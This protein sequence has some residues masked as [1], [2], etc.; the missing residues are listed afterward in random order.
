MCDMW[1][2][3]GTIY[4]TPPE[5]IRLGIQYG[6]SYSFKLKISNP[7]SASKEPQEREIMLE[8][9]EPD[10]FRSTYFD[11]CFSLTPSETIYTSRSNSTSQH[12]LSE[13]GCD[14]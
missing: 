4:L 12:Y 11:S 14:F 9:L 6:K 7:L 3:K 5:R 2:E 8:F 1:E 13:N 10:P